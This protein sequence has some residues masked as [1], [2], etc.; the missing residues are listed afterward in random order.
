MK[1]IILSFILIIGYLTSYSQMISYKDMLFIMNNEETEK[2]DD[3]LSKKGFEIGEVI[4]STDCPSFSWEYKNTET[5]LSKVQY[6]KKQCNDD[7]NNRNVIYGSSNSYNYETIRKEILLMGYKKLGENTH[8]DMLN[9]G[10]EKGKYRVVFSKK[11][12]SRIGENN[13]E[14]IIYLVSLIT[15]K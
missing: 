3:F 7:F 10:F 4:N 6:I 8:G 5:K 11:K 13:K 12:V 14:V 2:I 1:K 9:I 15:E